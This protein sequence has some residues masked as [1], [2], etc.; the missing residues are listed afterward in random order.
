MYGNDQ[1]GLAVGIFIAEQIGQS[2]AIFRTVIA[3]QIEIFEKQIVDVYS[4][5][6]S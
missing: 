6:L 1:I 5:L 3:L 2:L 4:R